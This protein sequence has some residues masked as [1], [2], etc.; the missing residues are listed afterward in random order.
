[1]PNRKMTAEEAI[2]LAAP[3]GKEFLIRNNYD[4]DKIWKEEPVVSVLL[5]VKSKDIITV[6]FYIPKLKPEDALVFVSIDFNIY[7]RDYIVIP[8]TSKELHQYIK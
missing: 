8:G 2:K 5:F 3:I 6:E 1:M 7:T 4:A